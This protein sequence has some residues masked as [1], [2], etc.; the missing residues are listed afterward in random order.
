MLRW[1]ELVSVLRV[2]FSKSKVMGVNVDAIFLEKGADFLHC[3]LG[4]LPFIYLGLLVGEN[5]RRTA[6]WNQVKNCVG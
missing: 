1:I 5:P 4:S 6:T 2:N 3:K